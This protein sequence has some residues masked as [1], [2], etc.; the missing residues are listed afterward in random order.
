MSGPIVFCYALWLVFDRLFLGNSN[1]GPVG[2]PGP[3]GKPSTEYQHL[4][5]QLIRE[6]KTLS[7]K[8]EELEKQEF[9]IQLHKNTK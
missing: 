9:H 4:I 6:I 5:T 8:V 7:K 2:P 1:V 3:E